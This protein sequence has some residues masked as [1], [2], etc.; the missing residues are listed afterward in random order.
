MG[1]GVDRGWYDGKYWEKGIEMIKVDIY[2][3]DGDYLFGLR[4]FMKW[5]MLVG[6]C[7]FVIV[8]DG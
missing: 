2:W 8:N 6:V 5:V 4:I 3:D 7:F 1:V